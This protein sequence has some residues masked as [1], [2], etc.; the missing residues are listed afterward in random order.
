[1]K[2]KLLKVKMGFIYIFV[3]SILIFI[4]K[5][6]TA[7]TNTNQLLEGL[8][9]EGPDYIYEFEE[10]AAFSLTKKGYSQLDDYYEL[11]EELLS[12]DD[13][14]AHTVTKTGYST[15]KYEWK[16][17]NKEVAEF[18]ETVTVKPTS[19]CIRE[20]YPVLERPNIFKVKSGNTVISC[21]IT[22]DEG[23]SVTLSKQ[24]TVIKGKPIKEMQVG[25]TK[26]KKSQ[27]YSKKIIIYTNQRKKRAKW[28]LKLEDGWKQ[29]KTTVYHWTSIPKKDENITKKKT[30][31][32]NTKQ[33]YIMYIDLVNENTGQKIKYVCYVYRYVTHKQKLG[34]LKKGCAIVCK[35][36]MKSLGIW[37][38]A[39]VIKYKKNSKPTDMYS[40]KSKK[41]LV[42]K[43]KK[44]YGHTS[45]TVKYKNG[46][47]I[48]REGGDLD[49][50][51]YC[52]TA[53]KT[54]E[55]INKIKNSR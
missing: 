29:E 45:Q 39:V 41:D 49:K 26:I 37:Y 9:I 10:T 52:K 34:K 2:N 44:Y 35:Q 30:L 51:T 48:Y 18:I 36:K 31:S 46:K 38:R 53:K 40:F 24:L 7:E 14:E 55:I 13:I 23:N 28:K 22:D 20:W 3:L 50:L 5:T 27:M 6:V 25:K 32:L 17:E 4:P 16:S 1:M 15:L 42:L 47:L 43:L 11:T 8:L 33:D 54:K 19:D 12:N 21:T